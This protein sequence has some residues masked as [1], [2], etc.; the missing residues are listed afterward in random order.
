MDGRLP[1]GWEK[2][3][4]S[5]GQS[6]EAVATRNASGVILNALASSTPNLIGGSADLAPSNKTYLDGYDDF[7]AGTGRNIRFG[8]REFAACA[9]ANG[10]AL[11]G[12]II[13]YCAT[14]LV[15]SDYMRPAIRLA[16]LMRTHTILIFS[17][18]SIA[19]GEDGP[20][21][22]PVEQTMSLRLVPN[23]TVLRPADANET[24]ACWK[25]A[26]GTD[27]PVALLLSRQKLP[28]LPQERY[29]VERGVPRGG[30]VL[31]EAETGKP[32]IVLVGTGSEVHLALDA[33][34]ALETRGIGA[35]VVSLPSWEIFDRQAPE[36]K[37]E[38]LPAGIPRLAIEAGVTA[39]WERYTGD[40]GAVVGL[41][42]FGVSAPGG[43]AYA[44]LGFS[45]R[46]VV[47][48]AT[49]IARG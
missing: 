34:A 13:P 46:T 27:G 1:E 35:R 38:V 8:V 12:G 18:D 2:S 4:P 48:K 45:V 7:G 9:V 42:G 11:H 36:Y 17:H 41:D 24:A 21:H 25:I 37:V 5:F 28:V 22:Q 6:D 44:E 39:G 20:T 43:K 30:Y 15:F 33:A 31:K 10:L 40:R 26:V 47:E 32:D 16:G 23:L 19:V 14:F 49:K 3:I 29:P